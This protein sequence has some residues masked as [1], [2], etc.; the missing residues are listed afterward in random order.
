[1]L[2]QAYRKLKGDEK[3]NDKKPAEE[4]PMTNC[5]DNYENFMDDAGWGY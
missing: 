4:A 2:K 5:W 1:M 3:E